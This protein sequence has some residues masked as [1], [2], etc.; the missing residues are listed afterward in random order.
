[1]PRQARSKSTT[2]IYHVMLRGNE[3]KPVFL[4]EEDKRKFIDIL[5]QK[6]KGKRASCMRI[7]LWTTMCI[8]LFTK[9]VSY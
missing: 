9:Q 3:R 7:A 8:W 1:M 4:D 6:K 2:G 5:L